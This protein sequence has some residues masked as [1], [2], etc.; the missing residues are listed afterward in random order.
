MGRLREASHE[1]DT[2]PYKPEAV[3]LM[4]LQASGKSSFYHHRFAHTHLRINL[5]MLKTRHREKR[6]LETC[7]EIQQSFVVDNTNPTVSD[8]QRYIKPAQ[9]R[10]FKVIGYYFE[11]KLAACLERNRNR[12]RA[13]QI[14]DKGVRGTA[15]RLTRPSYAE[16][17]DNLYYVTL[18]PEGGFAIADWLNEI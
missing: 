2:M 7:L 18:Q 13:Q 16:G 14:P 17:F 9:A 6:L 5:D 4:G 15:A 10:G 12:D 8:R 11:S 3:I 1:L